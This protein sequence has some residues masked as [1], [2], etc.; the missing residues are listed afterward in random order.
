M[1]RENI[2][3]ILLTVLVVIS[4]VFTWSIWTFQPNFSEGSSSAESMVREKHKIEKNTQKLSETVKPREMFI[5]DDGAHYKVDDETLY[6]EVWSDL[7]HWDVKGIKDI[8]DHYDKAGFK[9]WFYGRGGSAAK[10]DLQ[11]SDT[12]PIDIIQTL[13]KWS[14]QSF[15][16]SSFDHI[17]IPFEETKTNKKIY[18]VS[19]SK[20]LILEVTVESA[21]YRN[22]MNDL[23]NK[24]TNMPAYSLFSIGTKKEF[25]LPNK[26]LTMDKKEFVTESIKTNTFK[27][28]LFSDPSIVREDSNYNNRNVLTDGISRLDVSLTQRQVQFQQRNLVQSTSYQTGELIKKSQKYLEDT[29]SWTDHY[30]F[31]NINDSQQL[32]FYIFMDQLP[33]INSMSKPFGGTSAITVQWAND[34]ILSY[35]RPN[36]SLGTN[37][38]KTSETELMS[39]SEVRALLSK[40]TAYDTDKI[41]QI[42]PAYQL[43]STSTNDDP[44]VELEPVWAMKINGKMVPITKELLTKEGADNGVE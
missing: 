39:G 7:P 37:P 13:L 43:V 35:K 22:I 26:S 6:D 40:Q 5:H 24:K 34:D 3:T 31:F 38:I 30:Q 29:G 44:L 11:F 42:F 1:K 10:L 17:M 25:L 16:Y 2:K 21:N 18:L 15:E 9:S 4:L 41:D 27:Q 28:A 12:I 33:V 36:Y 14:N 19:Y 32:S 8:S 23:Q 20:Q